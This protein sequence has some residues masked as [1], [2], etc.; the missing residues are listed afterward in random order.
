MVNKKLNIALQKDFALTIEEKSTM[1]DLLDILAKYINDLIHNNFEKLISL[2]YRIDISEKKLKQL[3]Q[4]Q[5]NE[6]AG[7]IIA[8]MVIERELQ[9]INSRQQFNK[10][11]DIDN[12][13]EKW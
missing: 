4:D 10:K 3:L 12:D 11:E 2:L 9:K 5:P 8:R 7:K 6:D 1:Q 13:E